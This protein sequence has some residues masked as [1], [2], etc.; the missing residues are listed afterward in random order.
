MDSDCKKCEVEGC[1]N[2]C[3][4]TDKY[5]GRCGGYSHEMSADHR[6]RFLKGWRGDSETAKPGDAK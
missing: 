6:L 2:F 5:C 4:L 1:P 3:K